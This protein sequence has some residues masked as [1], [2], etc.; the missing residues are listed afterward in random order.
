[1][2]EE[3]EYQRDGEWVFSNIKVHFLPPNT[4]SHLQPMD[5]GIIRSF[6]AKY[7]AIHVQHLIDETGIIPGSDTITAA[8]YVRE[9][10]R[11]GRMEVNDLLS[12]WP[13]NNRMSAEEWLNAEDELG[14]IANRPWTL[15]E[16]VD[17]YTQQE[18]GHDEEEFAFVAGGTTGVEKEKEVEERW[19]VGQM[20][21]GIE[22]LKNYWLRQERLTLEEEERVE[23]NYMA[24]LDMLEE[25][26]IETRTKQ[27]QSM[28]TNFFTPN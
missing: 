21:R 7:R 18:D 20:K 4:T 22:Q 2:D 9:N 8:N 26:K 16:V 15:D 19:T 25:L 5:A 27:K 6:K 12:Q 1:M 17:M 3:D 14:A 28:L 10:E 11:D 13:E 23:K 24:T